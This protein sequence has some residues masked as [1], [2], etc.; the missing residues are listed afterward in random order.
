M[1]KYDVVHTFSASYFS[2]VLA[3]TPAILIA[4]LYGKKVLLNYHSGEAD[5]HLSA[6]A[7]HDDTDHSDSP[8]RSLY[9][10]NTWYEVFARHGLKARAIFNII[11]TETFRFRERR[12]VAGRFFFRIEIWSLTMEWTACCE[13]LPS[14]SRVFPRLV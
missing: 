7:T 4:K 8:T 10:Q 9:R 5:D 14:F 13:P 6:L 2:F 1:R 3:P 11:G 12:P